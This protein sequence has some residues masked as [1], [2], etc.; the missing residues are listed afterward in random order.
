LAI[1]KD[2]LVPRQRDENGLTAE[3]LS[4]GDDA[5][6]AVIT[7]YTREAGVRQLERELGRLA[8]K[9]ARRIAAREVERAA[10]E[11]DDVRA[12]LGRPRVHPEKAAREDQIG[13]ATG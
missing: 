8:R 1:A 7:G 11:R 5:I 6:A 12:L 10:I 9:V 13:T 4:V 2:Y 3:Q